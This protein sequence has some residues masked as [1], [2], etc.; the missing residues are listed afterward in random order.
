[1]RHD[2]LIVAIELPAPAPQSAYL[3]VRERESYEYALVSAAVV[4]ETDGPVIRRAKIALGSVALRPWRL[5]AAEARLVGV[6]LADSAALRA[7]IEESFAEARPLSQNAYKIQ[8]AKNAALR[9]IQTA[10]RMS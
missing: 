1:L 5:T 8:L 7:A 3:K 10:G 2:E 4:L 6:A 9:A